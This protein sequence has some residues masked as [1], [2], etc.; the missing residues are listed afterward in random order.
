MNQDPVCAV[1]GRTVAKK[2]QADHLRSDHLGPHYFRLNGRPYRT[3]H[4]SMQCMELLSALELPMHG[5]IWETR[6]GKEIAYNHVN[7][8]DLTRQPQLFFELDQAPKRLQD[9]RSII[10]RVSDAEKEASA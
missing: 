3:M 5:Y 7:A 6:D 10:E 1:C 4:P 2:D 9:Q 8:I